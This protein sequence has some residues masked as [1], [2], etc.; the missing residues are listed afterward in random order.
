MVEKRRVVKMIK[1]VAVIG[2]TGQVGMPLA[3]SLLDQE[4]QVIA[5]S[6]AR[7]AHNA[8]RLA[9]LE[10]NGARSVFCEDLTQVDRVAEILQDCD[11][12]VVC[13]RAEKE[14]LLDVQPKVLKAAVKAGVKRFV[15]NEFGVHTQNIEFGAGVIF[16][17]KKQFQKLLF[18]SGLEWTLFYN[19]GIFEY[20]LPNLRFFE[21]I[22]TFGNLDIPIYTHH[23]QDIGHIAARVVVDGRT[24]N[25]CVQMDYNALSQKEML[26]L[27]KKHWPDYPFEYRHYSTEYILH[28][29]EHATDEITAKKGTETDRERW[30]INYVCYV[31]GKLAAFNDETLR[32]SE[33]FPDYICVKPEEALKDPEFVFEKAH[34]RLF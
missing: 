24:A 9:E 20:F 6:R 12:L 28:M 2:A 18:A 1:C 13:A 10:R 23:I 32:T 29:K 15:P 31:A 34:T 3:H 8:S 14:F 5:I 19:G 16:D 25:R 30:G 33:L 27:L 7:S 26:A 21:K 17:Y 4:H 22:T 11:T